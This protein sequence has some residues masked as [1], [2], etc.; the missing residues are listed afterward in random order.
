MRGSSHSSPN[1]GE[2]ASAGAGALGFLSN[3]HMVGGAVGVNECKSGDDSWYC[4]LSKGYSAFMMILSI[5][6]ILVAIYFVGRYFLIPMFFPQKG[7]SKSHIGGK[8]RR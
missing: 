7:G 1:I 4:N 8:R 2:G 3:L 6:G 5:I